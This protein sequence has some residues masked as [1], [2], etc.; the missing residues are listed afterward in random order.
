MR[1]AGK[2]LVVA[3]M[4]LGGRLAQAQPE[5]APPQE[6]D[7]QTEFHTTAPAAPPVDETT[8]S[9]L[10]A[11]Q[12]ATQPADQPGDTMIQTVQNAE[13]PEALPSPTPSPETPAPQAQEATPA[14]QAAPPVGEAGP[15]DHGPGCGCGVREK[16]SFW[17][18][19]TYHEKPCSC[20]SCCH[21]RCE[22]C[23][24]PPL[25]I[26]F[27]CHHGGCCGGNSCPSALSP[28]DPPPP[29]GKASGCA[30]CGNTGN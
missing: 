27:V 7:E 2:L 13:T 21:K 6:Q 14:P 30:T 17:A 3:L 16:H 9:V 28:S 19:L 15:I 23:G 29:T 8:A 25:Y 5:A 1:T 24:L 10:P 11:I 18:W 12:E 26:F 4:L 22:P 20:T